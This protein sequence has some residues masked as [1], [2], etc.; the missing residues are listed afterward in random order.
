MIV[1]IVVLVTDMS[2]SSIGKYTGWYM[3]DS[4]SALV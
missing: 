1:I 3:S 4:A 2:I